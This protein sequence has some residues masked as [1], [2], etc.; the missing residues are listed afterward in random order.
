[1]IKIRHTGLVT[2]NLKKSFNFWCKLIGFRVKI[3]LLEK[4]RTIDKIL[5]YKNVL[6]KTFKLKDKNNNLLELLYFC[7]S[8]KNK[9]NSIKAYSEGFTHISLTVKDLSKLYKKLIKAKVTFNSEPVISADRKVLITYCK[10]PEGSYLE[11]VQEL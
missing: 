8:P 4:G 11:L 7:N 2:R 6:V 10:T 9:R 3:K 1:M 5:G